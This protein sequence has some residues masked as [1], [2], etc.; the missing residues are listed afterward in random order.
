MRVENAGMGR[1]NFQGYLT[2]ITSQRE[3]VLARCDGEGIAPLAKTPMADAD[4]K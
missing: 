3:L 4:G 2:S 1:K